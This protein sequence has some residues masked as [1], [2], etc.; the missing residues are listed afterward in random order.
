MERWGLSARIS[1]NISLLRR[2]RHSEF[3][4]LFFESLFLCWPFSFSTHALW[5][6]RDLF[7][8]PSVS[9]LFPFGQSSARYC[10]RGFVCRLWPDCPPAPR[11]RSYRRF[12]TNM[13]GCGS[14]RSIVLSPFPL[15]W[16]FEPPFKRS[17]A[18]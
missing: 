6:I 11:P 12:L 14:D 17:Y 9:L 7:G 16:A 10:R 4:A 15:F 18:L 5:V 3:S 13:S 2:F 1:G 8:L